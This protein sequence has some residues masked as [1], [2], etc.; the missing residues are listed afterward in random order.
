ML[1]CLPLILT[2]IAKSAGS[3]LSVLDGTSS[4]SKS[5]VSAVAASAWGNNMA[6]R[7]SSEAAAEM[8]RISR[9]SRVGV[10][11]RGGEEIILA[12][13]QLFP[14]GAHRTGTAVDEQSA[15]SESLTRWMIGSRY[16][17]CAL[18]TV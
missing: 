8:A 16:S 7:K 6:P 10:G 18:S 5:N 12:L 2:G 4:A 15:E 9:W 1:T 11:G 3:A 14:R 17:N 13:V